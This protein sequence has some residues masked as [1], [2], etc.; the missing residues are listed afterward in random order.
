[1]GITV[2]E[3][4][5]QAELEKSF[6]Y[7]GGEQ[8]PTPTEAPTNRPTS[9]LSALQMTSPLPTA[10]PTLTDTSPSREPL[11][12]GPLPAGCHC[13]PRG[14]P[15][16]KPHETPTEGPTVTPLPTATPFTEDA[17]NTAYDD[18]IKNLKSNLNFSE[19]DLR[20]LVESELHQRC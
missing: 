13:D 17:F 5:I 15:D 7:Y 4:E 18:T 2:T 8:P 10:T 14:H 16:H 3:E 9:T 12:K 19:A 6:G 11:P 1:M 20:H